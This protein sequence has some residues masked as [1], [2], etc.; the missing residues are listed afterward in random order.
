MN[1]FNQASI[2]CAGSQGRLSQAEAQV[3]VC[4]VSG[5]TFTCVWPWS[6]APLLCWLLGGCGS[7][8]PDG[9]PGSVGLWSEG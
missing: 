8:R 9:E 3:V 1:R 5:G 7:S 4:H 2:I 6:G